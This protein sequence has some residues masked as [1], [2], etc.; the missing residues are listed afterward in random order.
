MSEFHSIEQTP[1][2]TYPPRMIFCDLALPAEAS[3]AKA[4]S[5]FSRFGNAR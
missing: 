4:G 5:R 3:F 2:S 1:V